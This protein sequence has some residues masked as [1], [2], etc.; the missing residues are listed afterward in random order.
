MRW[1]IS[2][3][4]L[5]LS[6][7]AA[8]AQPAAAPT[9]AP[10]ANASAPSQ[11]PAQAAASGNAAAVSQAPAQAAGVAVPVSW[12]RPA[13]VAPLPAEGK[14]DVIADAPWPGETVRVFFFGIQG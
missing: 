6:L 4:M 1:S 7:A 10:S 2:G 12:Q 5:A 11:A 13:D 14:F 8:C 3:A 9:S